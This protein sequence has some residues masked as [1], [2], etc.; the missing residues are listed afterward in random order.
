MRRIVRR[1]GAAALTV[2]TTILLVPA[3]AQAAAAGV[4][5]NDC[6][7]ITKDAICWETE[8]CPISLVIK[9]KL[10]KGG[11]EIR[12]WTEDLRATAPDD[13]RQVKD[14]VLRLADGDTESRIVIELVADGKVET[15]E[16]LRVWLS[17]GVGD[18]LAV[19]VTILDSDQG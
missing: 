2:L 7:V 6:R 12:F 14:G 1:L 8:L 5:G 18:P 11:A 19:T 4:C 16:A 3:P 9:G 15:E 10:P 13:Y 17:T